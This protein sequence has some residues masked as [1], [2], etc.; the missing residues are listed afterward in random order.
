MLIGLSAFFSSA[1]TALFS[2]S[3]LRLSHMEEQRKQG[4]KTL[5]K[6]KENPRRLLIT[7]L[8]GN[9]LVN[10]AASAMATVIALELFQNNAIALTTGI[11]TLVLLVFGEI[12]PKTFATTHSES[13]SLF[14]AKPM[15]LIMF[16]SFPITWLFELLTKMLIRGSKDKPLITE[17]EI[18]SFV[19]VGAKVGQIKKEEREMIHQIFQFDDMYVDQIMTPK[20]DMAALADTKTI[21]DFI[22]LTVKTGYSRIPIFRKDLD[23]IIGFVH[24]KDALQFLIKNDPKQPI[25]KIMRPIE[26]VP[27]TKKV[28]RLL[29][30]FRVKHQHLAVI[31]DEHG[32]VRGLVT[33]EDVL[34]EIVGEIEDETDKIEPLFKQLSKKRWLVSGRADLDTVS[35]KLEIDLGNSVMFDTISGFVLHKLDRMAK[36]KDRVV[37]PKFDIEVKKII[38][39]RIEQVIVILK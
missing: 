15:W 30:H 22:D 3:K 6:I 38:E 24:A 9:N 17:A 18:K 5:I 21:Q 34:E 13:L 27:D 28:D 23:H 37:T 2:L 32:M 4:V 11:M 29:K 12:T 26:F 33:I 35:D 39:N 1:E 36:Q 10:I 19:N 7:I 16:I 20:S 8:L 25:L 14:V 31:V